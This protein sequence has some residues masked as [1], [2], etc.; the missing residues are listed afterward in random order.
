MIEIVSLDDPRIEEYR[1]LPQRTGRLEPGDRT[2]VESEVVAKR[3]LQQQW[4]G[5]VLESALLVPDAAERLLP[6]LTE[7]GLTLDRIFI[8]SKALMERI[9]GYHLHQGVFLCIRVPG[10]PS[11]ESLP[12]PAVMVVGVSSSTNVGAIARS[13]AAF[14]FRSIICDRTS[15]SPWLRRCIRVSMG[16]VFALSIYHARSDVHVL[17]EQLRQRGARLVGAEVGAPQLYF[18]FPW[19]SHDV[20]IF[21]SEGH[22]LDA[23]MLARLDAAVRIPIAPAVESLN[24]AAA[25][26]IVLADFARRCGLPHERLP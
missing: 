11:V 24:V 26:A 18:E 9:V 13:A 2:I 17:I 5:Q 12:L 21:G 20:V 15:A 19:A 22:G 1:F 6:L 4:S 16:A 3:F 10:Q 25:A 14:G 23:A 7:R 8:A